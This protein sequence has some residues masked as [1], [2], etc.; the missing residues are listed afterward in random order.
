MK[1]T[2]GKTRALQSLRHKPADDPLFTVTPNKSKAKKEKAGVG[3]VDYL[4][5]SLPTGPNTVPLPWT[6]PAVLSLDTPILQLHQE[7]IDFVAF[8]TPAPDQL[9]TQNSLISELIT[10]LQEVYPGLGLC[11]YGSTQTGLSLPSSDLDLRLVL[12]ESSQESV[13]LQRIWECLCKRGY[14]CEFLQAA[15]VP[16]VRIE[17]EKAPKRVEISQTDAEFPWIYQEIA[18]KPEIRPLIILLKAYFRQ[19]NLNDTYTGGV[20]SYLLYHLVAFAVGTHPAYGE[21]AVHYEKYSLGHYLLY[22]LKLYGEDLD[23]SSV[24]LSPATSSTIRRSQTSSASPAPLLLLSPEAPSANL[25][26][27]GLRLERVRKALRET[28]TLLCEQGHCAL[29]TTPLRCLINPEEEI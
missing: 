24:A 3:A 14:L 21:D 8:V 11:P 29:R 26:S 22:F 23:F 4:P 10:A 18:K 9:S 1:F 7:I 27:E 13:D 6:S 16:I 12:P 28:Y 17:R 5:I 15:K 19:R 20:G 25:A 2:I